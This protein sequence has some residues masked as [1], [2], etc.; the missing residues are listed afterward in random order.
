MRRDAALPW[1]R[2]IHRPCWRA[3]TG[4]WRLECTAPARNRRRQ[5][6]RA[7]LWLSH[8]ATVRTGSGC[9]AKPGWRCHNT[10][11]SQHRASAI[12]RST[13]LAHT[14]AARSSCGS[15]LTRIPAIAIIIQEGGA[16]SVL[17]PT[18]GSGAA[19]EQKPVVSSTT[20]DTDA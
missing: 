20:P 18:I 13:S 4:G 16:A 5:S 3:V 15:A 10:G 8:R 2:G 11:Q 12:P 6:Q 9:T 19:S 7:P 1:R 17:L 14:I